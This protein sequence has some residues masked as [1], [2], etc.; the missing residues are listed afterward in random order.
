M[1]TPPV[2]TDPL[3]EASEVSVHLMCH[4]PD[5][6]AAIWALKSFYYQ[7]RVS[8]PLV[9]HVQGPCTSKL[10]A[11]LR[12]HFPA[13]RLIFQQE[14]NSVVE[15]FLLKHQ[16]KNLHRVR[17]RVPMMQKLTDNMI[18]GG[19]RHVLNIDSDILFFNEPTELTASRATQALFQRDYQ[20][21]YVITTERARADFGVEL[22]PQLCAG[23]ALISP[24][25]F[26]WQRC[27]SYFAHPA[28]SALN[29]QAEQTIYALEASR[30][31]QVA[32]LPASYEI[33][34]GGKVDCSALKARHYAGPSRALFTHE[35]IPYLIR[36][37][38]LENLQRTFTR[39][40]PA[41]AGAIRGDSF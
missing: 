8:F 5:Y 39:R 20:D 7:A 34:P 9:M 28:F 27:E 11:D 2:Y 1:T 21:S 12:A 33:S 16:L 26:D 32:Y 35:G 19:S 22:Q 37:G 17:S 40:E 29:G 41:L 24:A 18:M 38:F 6:L 4:Q 23:L 10:E 25:L 3:G 31:R 15:A 30:S 36:S 13:A 14:A